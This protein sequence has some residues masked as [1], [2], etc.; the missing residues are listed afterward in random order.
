MLSELLD[1]DVSIRV[2][3]HIFR[4]DILVTQS[5]KRP[6]GPHKVI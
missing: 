5:G 4:T 2:V 1:P 3:E 6:D